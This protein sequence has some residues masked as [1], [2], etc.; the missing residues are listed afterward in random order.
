MDDSKVFPP[1]IERSAAQ[2]LLIHGKD[3]KAVSVAASQYI[4]RRLAAH[5]KK[6]QC[7][8]IIY[9]KCGHLLEPPISPICT[10]SY[11]A[12]FS[13]YCYEYVY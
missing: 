10:S 4:P 2:L 1:Q 13:E 5:G 12:L 7:D 11:H 6:H 8:V 3:D 9:P